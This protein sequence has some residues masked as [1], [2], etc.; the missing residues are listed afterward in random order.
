MKKKYRET[1]N[2]DGKYFTLP[3]EIFS[4]DLSGSEILIYSYLLYCEDRKTH[5]CHPSYK[6]I[7]KAVDMCRNTVRKYV[8]MLEQ[9]GLIHTETTTVTLKNGQK[10]NGNLCYTIL[11]IQNVINDCYERQLRCA[12]I[13]R[14]IEKYD[15]KRIES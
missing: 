8:S 4:L 7:A 9:K 1:W 11:P 10:R 2:P 14:K 6:T 5:Q 12:E 13:S 15:R 3:N